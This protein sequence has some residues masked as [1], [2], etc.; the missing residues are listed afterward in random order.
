MRAAACVELFR[1]WTSP[2]HLSSKQS[3]EGE[4]QTDCQCGG[5]C[6]DLWL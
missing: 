3:L 5:G 6:F 4:L 2:V 1:A